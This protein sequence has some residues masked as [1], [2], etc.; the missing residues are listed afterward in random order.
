M[1]KSKINMT[2]TFYFRTWEQEGKR[3]FDRTVQFLISQEA[4]FIV[5]AQGGGVWALN[6]QRNYTDRVAEIAEYGY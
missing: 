1:K 3:R 4:D 5:K 6:S 2:N